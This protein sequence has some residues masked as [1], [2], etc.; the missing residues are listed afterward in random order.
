MSHQAHWIEFPQASYGNTITTRK[1]MHSKEDTNHNQEACSESKNPPAPCRSLPGASGPQSPKSLRKSRPGL[2]GPGFK[3]CP[4][5][6]RKSLR[7]L[8]LRLFSD[9]GDSFATLLDTFWTPGPEGPGD[10]LGISGPKGPGDSF[11]GRVGSQ[12]YGWSDPDC[13]QAD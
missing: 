6:S 8:K 5:Q 13:D 10:S 11:K 9:S 4:K 2:D 3:M 7:S 1:F 12:H